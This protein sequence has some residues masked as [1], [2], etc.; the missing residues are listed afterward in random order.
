[1]FALLIVEKIDHGLAEPVLAIAI[2]AVWISA[3]LHGISAV[4]GAKWYAAR[5]ARMGDCAEIEPVEA[6]AKPLASKS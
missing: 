1:M 3:V 2:N 6:S 4:P 5:V